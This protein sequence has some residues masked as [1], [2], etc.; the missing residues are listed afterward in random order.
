M[1][2]SRSRTT[3]TY[4]AAVMVC[5]VLGH[6]LSFLGSFGSD[7]GWGLESTG[8]GSVWTLSVAIVAVL[9]M[10]LSALAVGRIVALSRE[11]GRTG[12]AYARYRVS[13]GPVDRLGPAIVRL[14]LLVL[15]PALILFV[16]SENVE[17]VASGLAAPGIGVFDGAVYGWAPLAFLFASFVTAS[18]L[19]LYRWRH[20]VL[21]ARIAA[22][23]DARPR[24]SSNQRR[25]APTDWRLPRSGILGSLA[26][27]A[28]PEGTLRPA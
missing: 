15:A 26:A 19:A 9:A 10:V 11:T 7:M 27:R 1:H 3:L 16:L 23:A 18:V 8:H 22:A 5:Y 4:L 12:S 20:A 28:P 25:Q 13:P 6:E 2:G 24:R 21:V 17:H 14:W